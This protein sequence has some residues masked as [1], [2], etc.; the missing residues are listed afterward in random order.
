M[1][2]EQQWFNVTNN[3]YLL[4]MLLADPRVKIDEPDD[5]GCTPLGAAASCI[6]TVAR[7]F[8]KGRPYARRSRY[9]FPR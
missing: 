8:Q 2:F 3:D 6:A 1:L 4:D 7:K 9:K 5:D